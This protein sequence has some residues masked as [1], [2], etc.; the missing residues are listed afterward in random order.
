MRNRPARGA[1]TN[2]T[3]RRFALPML[4]VTHSAEEARALGDHCVLMA[5][6]CVT[7]Q[8]TPA[9]LLPA[10]TRLGEVVAPGVVLIA[11]QRIAVPGLD[12]PIGTALRLER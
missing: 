9:D 7:A 10:P 8:G 11:G 6:G 5:A 2:V 4:Y 12:A 1:T 3:S